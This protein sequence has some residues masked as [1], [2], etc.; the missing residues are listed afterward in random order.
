MKARRLLLEQP[1]QGGRAVLGPEVSR[2]AIKVLRLRPGDPILLFD[3]N[4]LQWDGRIVEAT[5]GRVVAETGEARPSPPPAGPRVILATA[6]P[7]GRR[8]AR[9]VTMATEAGVDR[10][11][12]MV[13]SRSAVTTLSPSGLQRLA[14]HAAEASRQSGRSRVPMVEGVVDL[15]SLLG[16]TVPAGELRLLPTTTGEVPPLVEHAER[17]RHTDSVLLL[18]G[19]EGGFTEDE[20]TA[21]RFAGFLPCSLGEGV[22][23]VETAAVV[24]VALVRALAACRDSDS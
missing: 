5:R 9:L 15:A 21:A 19:P 16:R 12:P 10:I 8:L 11:V 13:S 22:L 6:L 3:G 18:V 1:P 17:L 7:K 2:H 20:E 4:G 14:R 23:R 24:S